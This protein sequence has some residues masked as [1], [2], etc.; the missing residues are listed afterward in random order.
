M[1]VR[2]IVKFLIILL[3][4]LIIILTVLA[5]VVFYSI[6]NFDPN[7]VRAELE[8]AFATQTGLGV[9]LGEVKFVW[10]VQPEFQIDS[11][12]LFSSKESLGREKILQSNLIRLRT[13]LTGITKKRFFM[14]SLVIQNPEILVKRN[15]AGLWNWKPPAAASTKK[16]SAD[17]SSFAQESKRFS[18]RVIAWTQALTSGWV[19]G[20]GT[21]EVQ[22]ATVYFTD[23]TAKPVIQQEIRNLNFQIQPQSLMKVFRFEAKG[24][25]LNSPEPNV[26]AEG[27][28]DIASRSLDLVCRYG[29]D[30]VF[31][32]GTMRFEGVMPHFQGLLKIRALDLDSVT[33][34]SY[35]SGE[36]V[37]GFLSMQT[38][39][40]FDGMDRDQVLRTLKGQGSFEIRDGAYKNRN[41]V[42]EVF[43]RIGPVIAISQA[44][45][46][47]LPPEVHQ[48]MR[49]TDTPFQMLAFQGFMSN[50]TVTISRA[51]LTHKDYQLA[52]KGTCEILAERVDATLQLVCAQGISSYLI[53]KIRELEYLADRKGQ[54]VIPFR[55]SGILRGAVVQPDL[56]YITQQL[57]QSGV[58]QLVDH[59]LAKLYKLLE[60]KK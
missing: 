1:V 15:A 40:S 52:G 46:G 53:K 11:L 59:G 60:P 48:M 10:G 9:E 2:Q 32:K 6:R 4:A 22:G 37:T 20:F 26:E 14:P 42:K 58:Q 39:F 17:D 5:G 21:I 54:V 18:T 3:I 49:G 34:E 45:G 7:T 23:E 43:D 31:L 13:D 8:K 56:A 41:L 16:S 12:K 47:E 25:V 55:Y 27:E 28:L 38:Q 50:G 24:S 33:P 51:D 44:L 36:Y 35:K 30:E 57:L 29:A 19:V